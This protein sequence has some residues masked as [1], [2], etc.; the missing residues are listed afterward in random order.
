MRECSLTGML[1]T[2]PLL[3]HYAHDPVASNVATQFLIGRD[4]LAAPVMDRAT[5]RVHVYL[6]PGDVWLD[7]WTTQLSPIQPTG[8][9]RDDEDAD[10]FDSHNHHAGYGAWVT[11]DAPL[12]W[13]AVFTSEG[14]REARAGSRGGDARV[15]DGA[16][17][18]PGHRR[19]PDGSGREAGAGA[20]LS[21]LDRARVT[22][23][24]QLTKR[25][26]P[27]GEKYPISF[28]GRFPAVDG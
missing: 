27:S 12:G 28:I 24:A 23:V 1:I 22:V 16:G 13:P 6:P 15:G 18:L 19:V 11:A 8:A 5:P 17:G 10:D 26:K 14:R 25:S 3:M 4:I 2:R 9:N 7:V 21:T 20:V